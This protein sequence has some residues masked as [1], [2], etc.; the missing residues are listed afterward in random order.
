M[1]FSHHVVFK[2]QLSLYYGAVFV[3]GL[4]LLGNALAGSVLQDLLLDG[5]NVVLKVCH[6]LISLF[7]FVFHDFGVLH[8]KFF[9][10]L[11]IL[12][13]DHFKLLAD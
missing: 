5:A 10:L 7:H 11:T 4:L 13:G 6:D 1:G 12:A 8:F 3:S 9:V 2:L